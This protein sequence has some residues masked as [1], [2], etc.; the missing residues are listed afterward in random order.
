MV[1]RMALAFASDFDL[2]GLLDRAVVETRE[3]CC[4]MV[5]AAVDSRHR[6]SCSSLGY[7]CLP[8]VPY[9]FVRSLQH[10]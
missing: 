5:L 3:S 2:V 7:L 4:Q 1:L 10:R 8:V 6:F 9:R